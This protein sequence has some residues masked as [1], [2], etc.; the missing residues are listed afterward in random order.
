[1]KRQ[2]AKKQGKIK[3]SVLPASRQTIQN[4]KKRVINFYEQAKAADKIHIPRSNCSLCGHYSETLI[5]RVITGKVEQL[6]DLCRTAQ[7]RD[8]STLEHAAEKVNVVGK[9]TK[10]ADLDVDF[11]AYVKLGSR[12]KW[13]AIRCMTSIPDVK[14]VIE[15]EK[16]RGKVLYN[17]A[18]I[19]LKKLANK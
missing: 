17:T 7:I 1:M 12:A 14:K 18:I 10:R 8:K 13:Y 6:C 15:R 16:L 3:E 2:A 5:L 11:E 4:P 9:K 19:R